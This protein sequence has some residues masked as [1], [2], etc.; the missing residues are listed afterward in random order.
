MDHM[1]PEMDGIEAARIIR[2]EIGTEYARTIPIIALTANAIVGNEEMFMSKGFQAFLSKPIEIARLDAVLRQWVRD[3]TLEEEFITESNEEEGEPDNKT[4][5]PGFPFQVS[6]IDF[7]KGIERFGGDKESFLQVLY[8]YAVNTPPLL[9]TIKKVDR[10]SLAG[11]AITVHGIKSSSRGISA[12]VAG[13]MAEALEKAA[14]EGN[15]DFVTANNAAFIEAA[16]TLAGDLGDM[17][18]R[19]SEEKPKPKKDKP[20]R[21]VL[22]R[23]AAACEQYYMDA[24]D[25]AMTELES[26]NYESGSEL[27][28]WLR[29][30]IDQMNFTQIVQ[31]LKEY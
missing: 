10:E 13:S 5:I 29:E 26:F 16:E 2:E 15:M 9:E 24:V 7:Q 14:K 23:L 28:E 31:K 3:K 1:M 30:N 4:K 19:M 21:D 18:Q 27:A 22:D 20:D 12:E 17:L 11:Y 8:S 6:G 25:I